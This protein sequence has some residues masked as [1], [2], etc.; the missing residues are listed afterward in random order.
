MSTKIIIKKIGG[1]VTIPMRD[2][3]C[4]DVAIIRSG[5]YY[6]NV[7]RRVN[8]AEIVIVEDLTINKRESCWTGCLPETLVEIVEAKITIEI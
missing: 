2:M 7:I 8:L 4:G 1:C 6:G 3:R 5:S